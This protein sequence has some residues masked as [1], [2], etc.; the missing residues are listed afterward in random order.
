MLFQKKENRIS[1]R[2]NLVILT[3]MFRVL[4]VNWGKIKK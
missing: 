2:K 4:T 1:H 3:F